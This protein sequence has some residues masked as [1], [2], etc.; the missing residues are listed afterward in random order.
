[1]YHFLSVDD[2]EM[3]Y[4]TCEFWFGYPTPLNES[5]NFDLFTEKDVFL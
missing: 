4:K 5:V 2:F 3:A 1:M